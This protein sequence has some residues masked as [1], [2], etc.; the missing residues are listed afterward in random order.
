[1]NNWPARKQ[2]L[3]EVIALAPLTGAARCAIP[4]CGRPTMKA[5]AQGLAAFHCRRHVDHRARH[6]S[7]F[8][9]T[10]RA[11]ELK[12]YLV[13]AISYVRVRAETDPFVVAAVAAVGAAMEGAGPTELATRLRGMP[14]SQRAKRAVARLRA[15]NVA[16]ERI[17]SIILAVRALIEE[18][19]GSHRVNEFR[20]VQAMK[21]IHRLASG[22]HKYWEVED[23]HGRKGR[24]EMHAFPKSTGPVLRLMGRVLEEPC[25][26][27]VDKHLARVIALKVKRYGRHHAIA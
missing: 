4:G 26:L 15:A 9:G 12:P 22:T 8:H 24:T 5:A 7:H 17:V 13:A 14:A 16:P 10:Y 27:V 2:K 1:M 6:G 25:E 23:C 19:P 21:A 20:T 18:D 11:S 3:R